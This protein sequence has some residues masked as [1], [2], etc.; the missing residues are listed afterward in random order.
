MKTVTRTCLGQIQQHVCLLTI[1]P[2][3]RNP[4]TWHTLKSFMNCTERLVLRTVTTA[5]DTSTT[6][7][8]IHYQSQWR[9]EPK[10]GH[11]N[12]VPLCTCCWH[13]SETSVNAVCIRWPQDMSSFG[14][15]HK[16]CHPLELAKRHVIPWNRPPDMSSLGIGHKTYHPLELATKH[17]I[18]WNW[19]QDISSFGIGHKTCHPLEPVSY[20]H[21]TLPTKIG[22]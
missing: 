1:A 13:L 12:F 19:P 8:E 15:G 16:T 21:L 17:V 18:P 9:H 14:I 3:G 6:N 20:T 11:R 10:P 2:R 5:Q 22:V 7:I 4:A